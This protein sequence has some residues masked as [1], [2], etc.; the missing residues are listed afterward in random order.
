M[1]KG[2]ALGGFTNQ[3][4]RSR[5]SKFT[6]QI[7][8]NFEIGSVVRVGLNV[9]SHTDGRDCGANCGSRYGQWRYKSS[10]TQYVLPQVLRA[11][12]AYRSSF[13][14]AHVLDVPA[15]VAFELRLERP[16]LQRGP[17]RRSRSRRRQRAERE[18][19]RR[20]TPPDRGR[21]SAQVNGAHL[22]A[23]MEHVS[24]PPLLLTLVTMGAWA[25][26]WIILG[27]RGGEKRSSIFVD[28]SG[29]GHM[30]HSSAFDRFDDALDGAITNA[31]HKLTKRTGS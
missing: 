2:L 5:R 9:G 21:H 1:V 31:W 16:K 4:P 8:R 13:D 6:I 18:P 10:H 27:A 14:R 26:V 24:V 30:T 23:L 28:E 7:R 3:T 22:L 20:V 25:I 19:S 29:R 11:D 17:P 15:R 12:H